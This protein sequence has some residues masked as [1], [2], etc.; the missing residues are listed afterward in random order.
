MDNE[1]LA[2][3]LRGR[4]RAGQ[5]V[6]ATANIIGPAMSALGNTI[7]GA[8]RGALTAM[9]GLPGDLNKLF[10]DSFGNLINAQGLPTTE[11]IQDFLPGQPISY[12]GKLSQ[13]MGGFIPVNPTPIAKGAV[14]VAKPVGKALGEKAYRMTEDMLQKEGLMPSVVPVGPNRIP[15]NEILFPNRTLESL[16]SAE[17]A[18]LTKF[19]KELKNPAAMRREILRSHFDKLTPQEKRITPLVPK[20]TLTTEDLFDTQVLGFGGDQLRAGVELSGIKGVP[21]SKN[22][23]LQGGDEFPFLEPNYKTNTGWASNIE[24]ASGHLS[25]I[26][27]A[28]EESGGRPVRAIKV[29]MNPEGANFSHPI[30]QAL[31]RQIDA[32]DPSKK[33]IAEVDKLIKK[34]KSFGDMSSFAGLRSD[35]IENQILNGTPE[36]TAGNYRKALVESLASYEAK[37]RGLPVYEDVLDAAIIPELRG[38]QTG[39]AGN[40]IYEPKY[41]DTLIENMIYPHGSY[42]HGIP[43]QAGGVIGGFENTIPIEILARKTY[44]KKIAEGKNRQQALRSM[45]TSHWSEHFDQESLDKAM[46]F[47]EEQTKK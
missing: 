44:N 36:I 1:T 6:D 22:V 39:E 5:P 35:E 2:S 47:L 27:K 16:N 15:S 17:K 38:K 13:K 10:T 25:N 46:K 41:K 31:V 23:I 4:N 24:A 7:Y 30:A 12:E 45:Q 33:S 37:K 26:N 42:T 19:D 20:Q 3:L 34:N 21:L 18:A 32:L 14:A 29:G 9:A 11:E 43:R 8:G 28:F 40:L